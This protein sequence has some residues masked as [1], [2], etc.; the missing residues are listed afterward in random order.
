MNRLQQMKLKKIIKEELK[1]VLKEN[2]DLKGV[3]VKAIDEMFIT[4]AEELSNFQPD[5][6]NE[7]RY[8]L[9][10]LQ[11]LVQE[12]QDLIDDYDNDTQ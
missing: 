6:I 10:K 5:T 9:K 4:F 12:T 7:Y 3:N 1:K 2:E 11:K 8:I